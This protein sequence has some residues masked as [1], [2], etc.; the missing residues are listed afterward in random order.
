[1]FFAAKPLQ[2]GL[3]REALLRRFNTVDLLA[4]TVLDQLLFCIENTCYLFKKTSYLNEESTVLSLLLHIVFLVLILEVRPGA[5]PRVEH[6]KGG[7]LT[8][9]WLRNFRLDHII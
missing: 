1:V 4:I 2:L 7:S 6:L 9:V 8:M 5:N 3:I